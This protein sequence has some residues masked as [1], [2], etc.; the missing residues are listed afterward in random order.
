[1]FGYIEPDKS[2]LRL[3]EYERYRAVYCGLCRSMGKHT[4]CVSRLSLNY[5][6]VFLAMIRSALMGVEPKFE[7]SRC[8]LHPFKKRAMAID[9][10][11]LEYCAEVSAVLAYHK[12]LDNIADSRGAKKLAFAALKPVCGGIYKRA[13][14]VSE[15]GEKVAE[16]LYKMSA[17][18][19]SE[20]VTPDTL[21]DV[22]GQIMAE[23][24]TYGLDG[25]TE[26]RIAAEIGNHT[27]RYVYLADALDDA[28]R[29]I[30]SGEFN[31]F[32]KQYGKEKLP[33]IKESIKTAVLLELSRLEA[34]VN[35]VDFSHCPGYEEIVKNIIYLGMP[36]KIGSILRKP[37]YTR[38]SDR[39]DNSKD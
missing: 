14:T 27:G 29:D 6:Y 8:M 33:E 21:A 34:A 19:K 32:V 25:E 26:R 9:D 5:D 37:V 17:L 11:V 24:F 7:P 3:W 28:E 4:G 36:E 12:V 30:K 20:E 10:R 18:E 2:Q 31:P 16:L 38:D 13:D 15:L 22:F 23:V 1:M 35:L 39:K